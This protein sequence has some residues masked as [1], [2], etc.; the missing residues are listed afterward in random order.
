MREN[1]LESAGYN[2]IMCEI[3]QDVDKYDLWGKNIA[4]MFVL[5]DVA[6]I[7][8]GVCLP[9]YRPAAALHTRDDFETE[10]ATVI[11]EYID[12]NIIDLYDI[13]RV[14]AVL[15]RYDDWLRMAGLNY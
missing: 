5:A 10:D 1:G 12:D 13:E 15:S 7:E 9:E 11:S 2:H 8:Y 14:F 6:Y 3:R 4:W